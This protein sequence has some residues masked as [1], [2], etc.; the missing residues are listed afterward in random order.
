MVERDHKSPAGQ[1]AKGETMRA[2]IVAEKCIGGYRMKI[3]TEYPQEKRVHKTKTSVIKDA[4]QMYS[5][6]SN[7]W[8]LKKSPRGIWSI[9]LGDERL[10]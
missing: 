4:L 7:T 3:G 1:N 5:S 9:E 2:N 8:E 10:C 6:G